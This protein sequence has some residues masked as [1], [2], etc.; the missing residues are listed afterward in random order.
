MQDGSILAT[1]WNSGSLF[2]WSEKSGMETLASGFKGPADFA[3]VPERRG[4][5]VVVPDLVASQL[6]MVHLAQ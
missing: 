5:M 2:R 3:V 6:R 4:L 1:D